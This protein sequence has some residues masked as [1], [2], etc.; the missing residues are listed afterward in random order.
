MTFHFWNQKGSEMSEFCGP[1]GKNRKR[2]EA[3]WGFL[4]EEAQKYGVSEYFFEPKMKCQQTLTI[5]I[6]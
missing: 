3:R 6:R 4:S 1:E 5:F 2:A